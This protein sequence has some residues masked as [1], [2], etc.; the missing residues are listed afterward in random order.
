MRLIKQNGKLLM[1]SLLTL[2]LLVII[3]SGV[4]HVQDPA[5]PLTWQDWQLIGSSGGVDF[6]AA[7]SADD[8]RNDVELKI[9]IDNGNNYTIQTRVDAVIHS[10]VGQ[11]NYRDN[12]GVDRLNAG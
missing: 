8:G 9:K 11:K 12:V 3:Q 4:A 2:S 7:I 1:A 6:L 5:P 10:G